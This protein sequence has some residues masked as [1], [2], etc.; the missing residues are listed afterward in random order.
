LR[1]G[2]CGYNDGGRLGDGDRMDGT[3]PTN[4]PEYTPSALA[5]LDPATLLALLAG[6][7]DRAPRELID[8]CAR[9]GDAMLDCLEPF[10]TASTWWL[11]GYWPALF[12]NKPDS[13]RDAVRAVAEDRSLDWYYRC[14]AVAAGLGMA[15]VRSAQAL[16]DEIDRVA[17]S[18]PRSTRRT[19][20]ATST[21][22]A[23]PG[24]ST[25]RKRSLRGKRDGQKRTVRR[26]HRP[27]WMAR[28]TGSPTPSSVPNPCAPRR[29]PA[30]TSRARAAVGRSTRSAAS[31]RTR[32]REKHDARLATYQRREARR[33]RELR[34][35]RATHP[36]HYR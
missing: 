34:S 28:K 30:G 2:G 19:R 15:A 26:T 33:R 1:R 32:G 4:L 10:A 6:D 36:R 3:A 12:R 35:A 13:T 25:L 9:R 21:G 16:D 5:A 7:E 20:H 22:F 8:E 17:R 14:G 23:I 27:E 29:A 18:R 11:V 24:S 31:P